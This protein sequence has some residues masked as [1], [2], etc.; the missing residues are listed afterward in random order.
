MRRAWRRAC[1]R[2]RAT[3]RWRRRFVG[4]AGPK[5]TPRALIDVMARL[6]GAGKDK[7]VPMKPETQSGV[8]RRSARRG[9]YGTASAFKA[10]GVSAMAKT[11]T[12]LMPSGAAL[13]LVVALTPADKPSRAI[14]VAA[15]GGAGIDAAAIAADDLP[16]RRALQAP[17]ALRCQDRDR[18]GSAGRCADGST[19]VETHRSRRLHRAGA[20]GRGAAAGRRCG[21]TGAGDHRA[22][23]CARQSQSA[24]PRR[25]RSLRHHALPGAAAATAD[26]AARGR[27]RRAAACCCTRDSRRSCS[28]PPGAAAIPS[29]RRR[30]GPARSIIRTSRRCMTMRART[31]RGGRAKCASSEIERALRAAGLRGS[32]CAIFAC[33]RATR[34]IASRGSRVEGFTPSGDAAATNSAWRSAA[35]PA[36]S[37]SRARRSTSIAP[38]PAID[39]RAAASATA[40]GCA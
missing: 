30:S 8:A 26:H 2:S 21:A 15:P 38:A 4:L 10:A 31:S 23:V 24:S 17:I 39:S 9:D 22:H 40:S 7:P 18:S 16:V 11:G 3:R 37:R 25:L 20:G 12:I 5:T 1:R 14:V 34:P 32:R 35:S 13:G 28:I 6:A 27:S 33:C 36:G 29:W 19:R